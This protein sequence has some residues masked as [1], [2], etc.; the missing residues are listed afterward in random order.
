MPLIGAQGPGSNISWRGNLDE[1]PDEFNFPDILDVTPGESGI[2]TEVTITG[3]NYKALVSTVGSGCSVSVTPYDDETQTYG[4]PGDFLPG[5]DPNNPI[6][7]RN[8]DKIRLQVITGSASVRSDYNK[9]YSVSVTIGSRPSSSWLVTTKLIDDDPEP[10]SFINESDLEINT[11]KISN[12]VVVNGID[13]TIGCDIFIVSPTGELKINGGSPERSGIIF[14]GDTLE[15]INTTSNFYLT[16]TTT[17][18][19][20]GNFTADYVIE[21]RA[22]D[23]TIDDFDFISVTDVEPDSFHISNSITISGADENIDGNNPIPIGITGGEYKI[24][25]NGSLIQDFTSDNG[26]TQNGDTITLRVQASSLYDTTATASLSLVNRNK[27]FSA[28]T[29]PRPIDTIPDQFTFNDQVDVD[30]QSIVTSNTIT[31]SGMTDFGD[32]G[33]ATISSASG[34]EGKFKVVRDGVTIRDYSNSSYNVRNGDQITLQ[35]KASPNSLG[36]VSATFT[37]SGTSTVVDLDGIAGSTT[38]TWNVTAKERFCNISSFSFTN[39]T[40]DSGGLQPGSTAST[41]FVATGFDFDCGMSVSTSNSNSYLKIGSRQGTSLNNVQIG[42]VVEVYMVAPYYDQSR[43]TTITLSSSFGTNRTANW[44]ISPVSPP[45]PTLTLDA[46]NRSVPFVFPDGGTAVLNY[47]YNY[48]TNSSV[49]TNFNVSSITTNSLSSGQRTGSATVSNLQ[50]GST[51]FTMTVRN[52]R[53]SRTDSVTV[54]VGT[55]PDPTI[56][57]CPSDTSSCSSSSNSSGSTT[58]LYW[59]T[60]NAVSTSSQDFNTNGVQNGSITLNN[61]TDNRTYRITATGAG[62]N[63]A[64]AT[65]SHTINLLPSVN[66]SSNSTNVTTGQSITLSWSSSFATSVVNTSGSGFN[67]SSLSGSVTLTPPRGTTTYGITVADNDGFQASDTVTIRATDDTSVDNFSMS[68]SSATNVA[69][70]ST[71][72]SQPVFTNGGN[73]V[74]GLSP[75]VSVTATVTNGVFVSGGTS[76]SVSNGTSSSSLRIRV[77]ASSNFSETRTGILN[78]GG[79]TASFPVTTQSCVTNYSNVNFD[80]MTLR[81]VDAISYYSNG[82]VAR[83]RDGLLASFPIVLRVTSGGG[84]LIGRAGSGIAQNQ[85]WGPGAY[86]FTVPQ[87]VTSITVKTLGG[88][89]AGGG[90]SGGGGGGGGCS[91][92]TWPTSPGTQYAISVG[93]GG[94]N[95]GNTFRP[96]DRGGQT[97]IGGGGRTIDSQGGSGGG[98]GTSGN[99]AR[100]GGTGGSGGA[101]NRANGGSGTNGFIRWGAISPRPTFG[102]LESRAGHGGGAGNINGGTCAGGVYCQFGTPQYSNGGAGSGSYLGSGQSNGGQCGDN[103]NV[104]DGADYGGGGGGGN[105]FGGRGAGGRARIDW[106]INYTNYTKQQ[107]VD[108]IR[109]VYWQRVNRGPRLDEIEYFY[110]RFKNE[111]SWAPTLQDLYNKIR[112]EHLQ[113]LYSNSITRT[114]T[115][116]DGS[117]SYSST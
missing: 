37:I 52:S 108:Q 46:Q 27:D 99:V 36:T 20:I 64:T 90:Y 59:K 94:Q 74:S 58:T 98:S 13:N 23:I 35:V 34:V 7:V 62:S 76:K 10:F 9:Q 24:E 75:G 80:G 22:A 91:V 113:T 111:P 68:P 55:P 72:E 15:L 38:D 47:T 73:S 53:G 51:T 107:V 86:T 48:V 8:N 28:T 49:T 93:G 14:D 6:I 63:P 103:N 83:D 33:T 18:V 1:H 54:I 102:A 2:S 60:T 17:T 67:T 50:T 40:G 117:L 32:E 81:R 4:L 100:V 16:P 70:S 110:N 89:G 82:Q 61:S 19:Q 44:T 106:V 71:H 5:D 65:A 101:G 109:L 29:R 85:N 21:T 57:L 39:I 114:A 97:S 12:A 77:T 69:R 112:D 45:L 25:R 88:G 56:T 26:L 66:L 11:E 115:N 96:G 31:L 84:S 42:D 92:A 43:T 95:V 41:S 3:I 79:I 105:S 78:I 104:R 116:C 30:R 87:G